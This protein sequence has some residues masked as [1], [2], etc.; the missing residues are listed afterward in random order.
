M[1]QKYQTIGLPLAD[2]RLEAGNPLPVQSSTN[3]GYKQLSDTDNVIEMPIDAANGEALQAGPVCL[4]ENLDPSKSIFVDLLVSKSA[5][6]DTLTM[7]C[8]AYLSMAGDFDNADSYAGA[9]KA[10]VAAGSWLSYELT[11]NLLSGPAVLCLVFAL[12]GTN[13]GDAT[14]IRGC[15]VRVP[16]L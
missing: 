3:T 2:F 12:G 15:K 8:E 11:A 9:A 5:D 14:Y 4:P 7:D 10:I 1:A 13:D 16:V 6:L